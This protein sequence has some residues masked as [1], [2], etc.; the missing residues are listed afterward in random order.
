M[1][2]W[3]AKDD[4][5]RVYIYS[6]EPT[7]KINGYW[8]GVDSDHT[9]QIPNEIDGDIQEVEIKVQDYETDR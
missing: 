2:L 7:C 6:Q 5:G 3:I 8:A 4:D 9:A 1:K